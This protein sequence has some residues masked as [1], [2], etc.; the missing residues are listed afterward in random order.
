MA[1]C[2]SCLNSSIPS[3]RQ[4]FVVWVGFGVNTISL[5]PPKIRA[6]YPKA[7]FTK[8]GCILFCFEAY[9]KS[10]ILFLT[11]C[12]LSWLPKPSQVVSVNGNQLTPERVKQQQGKR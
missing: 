5:N 3:T 11:G 4:I 7:E 9:L 6:K 1:A 2:C 8:P 12:L 10:K